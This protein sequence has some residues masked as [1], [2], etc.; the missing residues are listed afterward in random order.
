MSKFR[1]YC[2][3]QSTT[4]QIIEAISVIILI[5][6][7]KLRSKFTSN[8]IIFFSEYEDFHKG[9]NNNHLKKEVFE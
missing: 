1:I 2:R 3:V 7:V 4:L 6:E 8:Q 9:I 5:A